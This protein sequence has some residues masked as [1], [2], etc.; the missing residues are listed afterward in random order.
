MFSEPYL[1]FWHEADMLFRGRC[2]VVRNNLWSGCVHIRNA[3]F[4]FNS[5]LSSLQLAS[6]TFFVPSAELHDPAKPHP[7]TN[8]QKSSARSSY[9]VSFTLCNGMSCTTHNANRSMVQKVSFKPIPLP[10]QQHI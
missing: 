7:A 1:Y 8:S 5:A 10:L 3:V 6:L 4:S 2:C 9:T